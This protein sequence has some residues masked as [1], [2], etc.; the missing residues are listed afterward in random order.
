MLFTRLA[1]L[2]PVLLLSTVVD[3]APSPIIKRASI[4]PLSTKGRDILSANG[5]VF[6]YKSTNW[7]GELR[8]LSVLMRHWLNT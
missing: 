3:A 4:L 8:S 7:P 1:N 2:L 5:D 6:H